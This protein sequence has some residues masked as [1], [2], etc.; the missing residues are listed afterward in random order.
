[1]GAPTRFPDPLVEER[2]GVLARYGYRAPSN[3]SD[4]ASFDPDWSAMWLKLCGDFTSP[5]R[6]VVAPYEHMTAAQQDAARQYMRRRLDA[7][8]R[9]DQCKRA[10]AE[11]HRSGID[12]ALVEQYAVVRDAYEDAVEQ[13]GRAREELDALL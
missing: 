10:H 4:P 8:A 2:H 3:S 11:L 5:A 13:F 6:S 7:D 9:L 12:A 1:M